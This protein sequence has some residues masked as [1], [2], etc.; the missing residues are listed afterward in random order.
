MGMRHYAFT[1]AETV[2]QLHGMGPWGITYVNPQ[3]DPR[4]SKQAAK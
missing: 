4:T 3:D 2:F 1:K